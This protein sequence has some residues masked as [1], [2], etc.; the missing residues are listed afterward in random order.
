MAVADALIGQTVSHYRILEKLGGGGMGVVYKAEDTRLDRFVALKFL[1]EN[2][3]HDRPS[4][5]RFRREAKA[6]S[7]LNHSNIC[8]IHDIGEE[9]GRAF[10]AMEYLEGKT[11]KHVI[12]G[13]PMNVER[14]LNLAIEVAEAL[15]AAH[16]KGIVH[17][18]IKPA[19][20]FVTVAD[21]VKILDFGLAKVSANPLAT[22]LPLAS[23]G[24]ETRTLDEEFLTS[25]GTTVGTM[26]Y[27]SPEQVRG[28]DVDARTDL[29]SFGIVLYEMATG[30]LPFLGETSGMI[31]D[32]ILNRA[33]IPPARLNPA[34]PHDLDRVIDKALEKDRDV[35]YQHA[36]ELR[37]DLKRLRRDTTSGKIET[38]QEGEEKRAG[39]KK[40]YAALATAVILLLIIAVVLYRSRMSRWPLPSS[41]WM[42]LTNFV[43][44][45]T[46]PTI[47]PDGRVLVFLRGPSTF[48]GKS[49][50]YLRM[51]PGGEPVAL[52]HDGTAKMSPVFSPDGSQIAYSIPGRWETWVLPTLGGEPH[53]LLPNVSGLTWIN[54]RQLLFSE[55]RE[56]RHMVI[57]TSEENRNRE[58]VVFPPPG[59]GS[60]AHRSY[61][62]PDGK[63]VLA[64]WMSTEGAWQACRLVPL[65]GSSV[66]KP[67]GPPNA[68]C[69]F[70]GWSPD[71]QWMYFSSQVGG[72]FHIWRQRFPDGTPEQITSGVNEEEGIAV[73]PDGQSLI[74]SVGTEESAVWVH[75]TAGDR[76]ITS[77]GRAYF[78]EPDGASGTRVFSPDG[79]R[80]YYMVD[81]IPQ[82]LGN[83]VWSTDLRTGKSE[84]VV[85]E[86]EP[87]GFDLSP[88]GRNLAYSV[89]N[90]DGAHSLWLARV[91]HLVPP[92]QLTLTGK[93]FNPA[94]TK[95]GNLVFMSVEGDQSFLYE[96]KLDGRDR[97]KIYA[98]PVVQLTTLS[99]DG[100]W[101]VAQTPI[102]NED[103][104]RGILAIPVEGGSPVRICTG[105]CEVRWPLDGKSMFIAVIAGSQ[106]S[107]WNWETFI[108]PLA[109]GQVFPKLP[110]QGV[111]SRAD[112]AA[113]PGAK[114]MENFVLPGETAGIYAFSRITV[115]RNLFRIPLP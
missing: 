95:Q 25:P 97:R 43:D 113:L 88:D 99:P 45:A 80:L 78:V 1:P 60:M 62:S 3:A 86:S 72:K 13:K 8:I 7:A 114:S 84:R 112:A 24:E 105:L 17:R 38:F 53:L 46:S 76:Q 115:H 32:A 73:A 70:G 35:R 10:I 37:A 5:E 18:D 6:A 40:T 68:A 64:V 92:R 91:D 49:D 75:D 79:S 20:I 30:S 29:F 26:A 83:E 59:Q 71:G 36:S 104:P 103:V 19:N 57:A 50:V 9:N 108:V 52:T 12:A 41:D 93:E 106:E 77:E 2:V 101:A 16:T 23:K 48:A 4:L 27:M 85:S 67:V 34:I 90:K 96:M 87:F 22:R 15:D 89:G 47:S 65:D 63:W 107:M 61:V 98:G 110:P 81:R 56:G 39:H 33:P 58:R 21:R 55:L 102:Q 14:Q 42:Q 51:L 69:T 111:T 74:T 109:P 31:F 66:G 54:P 100:R 11:L 94:F 28:K 82:G 44:S